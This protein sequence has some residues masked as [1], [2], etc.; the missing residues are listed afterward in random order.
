MDYEFKVIGPFR[1]HAENNMF[2]SPLAELSGIY[3]W[4]IK[5]DDR[6][7]I[8]YI[9]ETGLSF[10]QRMKEH[11]IQLMGGN[12]RIPDPNDL[13]NG[14]ETILWNGLWRK[15]ERDKIN[16][17]IDQY[18]SLAIKIKEYLQMLEIFLIPMFAEERTRKL[19]EGNVAAYVRAQPEQISCLLPNDIRYFSKKK[20]N[21]KSFL[22]RFDCEVRILGFPETI[23]IDEAQE[24]T[25]F[26]LNSIKSYEST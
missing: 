1:L 5:V 19:I 11:L 17:F 18:E 23:Y 20:D 22:V 7:Y 14:R 13:R 15:K 12:Y 21:E 8:H 26:T 24:K 9:G 3:L 25:L 16:E 2:E 4:A 6:Y 10:K